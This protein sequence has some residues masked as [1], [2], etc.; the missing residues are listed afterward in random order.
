MKSDLELVP[1]ELEIIKSLQ[2]RRKCTM[3][4]RRFNPMANGQKYCSKPCKE[5][6]REER[7]GRT[8]PS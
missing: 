5:K 3:C 1:E 4:G 2:E 6:A 8:F 7:Y